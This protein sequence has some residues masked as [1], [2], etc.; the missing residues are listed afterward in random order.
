[1]VRARAQSDRSAV[2]LV[3]LRRGLSLS[4]GQQDEPGQQVRRLVNTSRTLLDDVGYGRRT[5]GSTC[6]RRR[7][8]RQLRI[9]ARTS[10]IVHV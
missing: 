8:S 5:V 10:R 9:S 3:R 2:Q 6:R 4:V 1:M 7:S